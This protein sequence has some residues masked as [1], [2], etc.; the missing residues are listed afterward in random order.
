M[1]R[2][3]ST[4]KLSLEKNTYRAIKIQ[5]GTSIDVEDFIKDCI[6][7]YKSGESENGL[8]N[9][10]GKSFWSE[11]LLR[12]MKKY[13]NL[14]EKRI[15]AA[16]AR[17][18]KEKQKNNAKQMQ[19]HKKIC[20]CNA[21]AYKKRYKCNAKLKKVYAKLCKLNQIKLNKI[22]L[23]EIRSIYPSNHVHHENKNLDG[24]M[25]KMERIE[26]ERVLNNCE[27]FKLNAELAI[28]IKEII[29]EMYINTET[30]EKTLELNHKKL[31]YALHNFAVANARTRI[32]IPKQYFK[33]CLL[34]ALDQTE[35]S[36][37]IEIDD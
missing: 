5:T 10:D 29:K 27:L 12:R 24:M 17:W 25:D 31:V 3:E 20:K 4:Y 21:S 19:V 1:L 18:N 28:E 14:K 30:R 6:N 7:E 13:E 2:N 26:F 16:N 32:Q 15:Q 8:F 35:L 23:K 33:K 22:K 37:Q 11:S 36:L 9:A 34:S